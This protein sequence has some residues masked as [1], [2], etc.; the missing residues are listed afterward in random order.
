MTGREPS[1]SHARPLCVDL[2]GTL[3]R[4]DTLMES[5]LGLLKRRPWL[6]I[7]MI[8]W[9]CGG[10]ARLKSEIAKRYMLDAATLPYRDALVAWVAEEARRRPV[11]LVTAAHQSIA[12]SV[13]AHLGLFDGIYATARLNL[14][15]RN[16]AAVLTEAFGEGGF[17]YAGNSRD[18][19]AVWS[20][21]GGAVVVAASA[22]VARAA[23]AMGRVLAEMD[24]PPSRM[25]TARRWLRALRIY[26]WVKNLLVFVAP[27]AAHTVAS[28]D[29]FDRS[30][31]A[32]VAFG[33][34]AS[35]VYLLNDLLDLPADRSH[36]RKRLRPFAAGELS[37]LQGVVA[38]IGLLAAAFVAASFLGAKFNGVLLSYV[39]VTTLYSVWLKQKLFLDV[40]ALAWLYTVRV[41]GGA[42]AADLALS[43]WLLSVCGYGFLCLALVKRFAELSTLARKQAVAAAHRAYQVQ[44]MPVVMA[45]G[46]ASGLVAS[47]VMALYVD[48][49]ASRMRYGHPEF[50][51]A[52]S[53]IV[54][55]GLGRMWLVAGRGQMHDDPIVFVAKD[56][57]S[58]LLAAGAALCFWAAI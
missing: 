11:Y 22:R 47:L 31:A 38:G 58:L 35:A 19:L 16:K 14:S 13:A 50:L 23:R 2:D 53:P 20:C 21:A 7:P 1:R 15:A 6:V 54:T 28:P 43:S 25:E 29:T 5:V 27:V 40:A 52:L 45:L 36:P 39:V 9:L 10:K 42:A 41:I 3:V 26:Q 24:P 34:A 37:L 49:E 8:A 55:I 17:D 46:C 48:S 4:T 33:F 51:W 57:V 56:R 12:A 18:D 30:V 44:D 32:F